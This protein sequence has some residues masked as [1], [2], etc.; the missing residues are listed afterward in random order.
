[1]LPSFDHSSR[2][3]AGLGFVF[4]LA[5]VFDFVENHN[6]RNRETLL[7]RGTA[8]TDVM[9][10]ACRSNSIQMTISQRGN[11]S[12]YFRCKCYIGKVVVVVAAVAAA[13]AA[14]AASN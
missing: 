12:F 6:H 1:M 5:F 7:F 4:V 9:N 3:D 13:T 8:A 10:F 14:A 2:S 11:G